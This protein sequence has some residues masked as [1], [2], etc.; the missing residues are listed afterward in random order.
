[1]GRI[2]PLKS[3]HVGKVLGYMGGECVFNPTYQSV[4]VASLTN[5]EQKFKTFWSTTPPLPLFILCT[6]TA[7]LLAFKTTV[8]LQVS[9]ASLRSRDGNALSLS[10]PPPRLPSVWES[11]GFHLPFLKCYPY[12][13]HIFLTM[14]RMH[15]TSKYQ[16][17]PLA[18]GC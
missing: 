7:K 14:Y 18:V 6:N 10:P 12:F 9:W 16:Q 5:L 11:D 2:S 17:W 8:Y 4:L 13:L 1:M 3:V 15:L